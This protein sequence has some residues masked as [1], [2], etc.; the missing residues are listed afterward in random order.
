ML[1]ENNISYLLTWT[2]FAFSWNIL[3][4]F[5][6]CWMLSAVWINT[7]CMIWKKKVTS[8]HTVCVKLITLNNLR[9]IRIKSIHFYFTIHSIQ[10]IS[11]HSSQSTQIINKTMHKLRT[12]LS[13]Q[14]Q[15]NISVYETILL[16]AG[17]QKMECKCWP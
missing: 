7:I 10:I 17:W 9:C 3:I 15:N 8:L 6:A 16:A 2:F 5:P 12:V 4:P 14:H 1:A 11:D 13:I